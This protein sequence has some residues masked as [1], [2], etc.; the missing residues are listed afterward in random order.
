MLVAY[1]NNYE[2]TV[3]GLFSLVDNLNN[4]DL[5][6]HEL[7]WYE[8]SDSRRIYLWKKNG[9]NFVGLVG[10]E[11]IADQ[12]IIRHLAL[13]PQSKSQANFNFLLD[14]LQEQYPDYQIIG[15]W[16]VAPICSLWERTR[17]YE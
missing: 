10:V 7:S 8:Q 15:C 17:Q 11:I 1:R 12:V 6:A 5:I 9:D 2:K 14:E 16:D 13:V 3:M 4:T